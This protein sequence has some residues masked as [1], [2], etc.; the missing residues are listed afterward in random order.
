MSITR[1][2]FNIRKQIFCVW[3]H[4]TLDLGFNVASRVQVVNKISLPNLK[5]KL[6]MRAFHFQGERGGEPK[7]VF[8]STIWPH[9]L[10]CARP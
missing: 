2:A 5:F 7:Y 1:G 6:S 10:T 8:P 9:R 3:R 4:G